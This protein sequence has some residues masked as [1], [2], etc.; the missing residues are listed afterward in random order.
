[1]EFNFLYRNLFHKYVLKLANPID[2]I[3]YNI[4]KNNNSSDFKNKKYYAH[5][6]CYDISR[7]HE[8]YGDYINKISQYFSVLI[9]YSIGNNTVNNYTFVI[10]KIPNILRIHG[11]K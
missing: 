5:L 6:H 1:M 8:I 9:T 3:N 11:R 4:I 7:F 10:L 2:K